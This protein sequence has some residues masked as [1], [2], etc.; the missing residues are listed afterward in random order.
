[1][2]KLE[3]LNSKK[4]KEIAEVISEYYG[5]NFEFDYEVFMN[6][7]NKIYILNKEIKL[8][9][10]DE[11]RLNSLGLYF[12]LLYDNDEIRL[13]IEGS[14]IIGK[15]ARK[16]VL[17]LNDEQAEL[18]MG[19]QDFKIDDKREGFILVKNKGD[20][21][22]CGKLKNKKLLNYVPKERRN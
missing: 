21:L 14:Q 13:S 18:W 12:G 2:Q 16:K 11:L 4:R 3:I 1:M 5:C 20:F 7:H 10:I 8:I 22:G 19:G 6:N 17:E 9:D 15:I